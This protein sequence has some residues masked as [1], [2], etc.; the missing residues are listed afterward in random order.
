M[1]YNDQTMYTAPITEAVT[2]EQS[3]N[4]T[5]FSLKVI[6]GTC[7]ILGAARFRGNA[8]QAITLSAGDSYTETASPYSFLVGTVIT[9]IGG[10][11]NL[12]LKK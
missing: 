1:Q 2:L 4:V 3:D 5:S 7:T 10:T 6:T 12:I 8:S 9:P 11:T